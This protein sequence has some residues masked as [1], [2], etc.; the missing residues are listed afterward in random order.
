VVFETLHIIASLIRNRFRRRPEL[1]SPTLPLI[2][3]SRKKIEKLLAGWSKDWPQD[4]EGDLSSYKPDRKDFPVPELVLFTLRDILGWRYEGPGEKVRWSVYG[5]ILGEPAVF[6]YRKFGFTV[7]RPANA[8]ADCKRVEG[9]L[10]SALRVVEKSLEPIAEHQVNQGRVT[11][12]NRDHEFK[13]RY[14]FFRDLAVQ[15]YGKTKEKPAVPTSP[16]AKGVLSDLAA[17]FN[18]V[19]GHNREG[20]FHATAMVDSY[21]SALEH[22]LV[23]LRGFSGKPM[24]PGE[25]TGMLRAKWDDKLTVLMPV[26]GNR[27]R[28]ELLGRLRR[29]KE[30]IRNPFA[31]GGVEND[32]GSLFFPFSK[33]GGYSGEFQPVR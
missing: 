12:V 16:E 6:E 24:K 2:R 14:M 31:H 25:L 27:E 32:G 28:E 18:K 7:A 21:F 11:I 13:R 9:Q 33:S 3:G 22:R 17:G 26:T 8:K 20:F 15:S 5:N 23:L 4:F 19:I 10:K 29:I 1:Q 30:R